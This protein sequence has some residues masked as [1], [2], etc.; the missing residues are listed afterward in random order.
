MTQCVADGGPDTAVTQRYI[1]YERGNWFLLLG[2]KKLVC[3]GLLGW[4]RRQDGSPARWFWRCI[5]V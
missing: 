4:F 3:D 5:S 2:D 1:I